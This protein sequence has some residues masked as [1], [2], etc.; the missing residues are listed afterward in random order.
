MIS[1]IKRNSSLKALNIARNCRDIMGVDGILDENHIVRH[2]M[3][4]EVVNT[5]EGNL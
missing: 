1:I 3:N 4:L 2:L 5:Y